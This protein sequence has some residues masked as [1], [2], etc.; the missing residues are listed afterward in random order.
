MRIETITGLGAALAGFILTRSNTPTSKGISKIHLSLTRAA[1]S[2]SRQRKKNGR[3]RTVPVH[4][5]V[6]SVGAP[7]ADGKTSDRRAEP[8]PFPG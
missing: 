6:F 8:V 4:G 1:M 3:E 5:E 7:A 2:R